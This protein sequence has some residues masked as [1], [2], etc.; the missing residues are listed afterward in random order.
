MF[1][2]HE[3]RESAD[4][5]AR[6]NGRGEAITVISLQKTAKT[7]TRAAGRIEPDLHLIKQVEQV[8]TLFWKLGDAPCLD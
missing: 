3:L 8:T 1:A 5:G 7:A 2:S 6:V 4:V